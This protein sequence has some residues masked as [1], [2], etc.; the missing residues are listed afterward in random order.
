[1]S[2]G[3]PRPLPPQ[4]IRQAV[5]LVGG[6]G[7]RLGELARETPKPL[8]SINGD[9]VFL[10][11]L[12]ENVARQGFDRILLLAGHFGEQIKARY[13][14]RRVGEA[15]LSVAIEPEPRG[16]GGA[17]TWSR[18]RLDDR[19]LLL[20]GDTYFDMSYRGL[21]AALN[22]APQAG[23]AIAL[24]DVPDA[25]R[26]GSVQLDGALIRS[27]QEKSV[28]E[29]PRAGLV[30]GGVY[31]MRR[32]AID[33]LPAGQSSLET[34]LFP[35]LCARNALIG[36]PRVGYFIDIGLPDTL[37]QAR[38]EL[39]QVVRRPALFLDR[40]GVI[41]VDHGYVHNWE[42]L[43][44]IPGVAETVTAYNEAGWFVFIVTNQ[45]GVAHGYYDE[46]A[47]DLLHDQIR[48]WLADKG[49]HVDAFYY[50]PF[51]PQAALEAYRAEHPDRKPRGGMLLRAFSQWP[52]ARE[53]SILIGDRQTDIEAARDAGIDGHMFA[54]E[55]LSAF[56]QESGLWPIRSAPEL[57][58]RDED[59]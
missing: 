56:V 53:G 27:F 14:D 24:R 55:D 8:M 18:D 41:N 49:A 22:R 37:S 10:D 45:A 46:A 21:E 36:L 19:F 34:D 48:D 20:N 12:I 23:A 54:G 9:K 57:R 40:D 35:R 52:V 51:H 11:L 28:S 13:D 47:V 39:P 4:R 30:N 44:F 50:C 32:T 31:L 26:Y 38:R 16:T 17:L 3:D 1:M 29:T 6:K 33:A 5:I 43:D 7:T 25:A 2:A 58:R 15:R 42:K 59:N